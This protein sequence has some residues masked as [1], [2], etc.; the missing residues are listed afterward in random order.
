MELLAELI[1]LLLIACGVGVAVKYVRIPYT[2]ALV[3]VGLLV[4]LTGIFPEILLTEDIVF[5]LILPPLLFEGALAM[6][7]RHLR[8]NIKPIMTLATAGLLL[9]ILVTGYIT[10]MMGIP[11]LLALIFAAMVSPTDPVSVLATFRK[12]G[13]PKRLTTLLEGESII[14]DGTAVVIFSILLQMLRSD[15]SLLKGF[16]EFLLVFAGGA[17]VGF[18]LGYAAYRILTYIDDPLIE[19]TITLILAFGTFLVA[20][21]LG[22]SGVIAV[23]AAGLIIGNYGTEFSMSPSTRLTLI[24]FWSAVVFLVNSLVFILIGI[25]THIF[26]LVKY[27]NYVAIAIP[28]VLIGRAVA[29][30]PVLTAFRVKPSWQH[31][32]FWGGLHGTIPVALA[33][34]LKTPMRDVLSAMVFGVVIFSLVIQGLSLDYFARKLFRK[35]ERREKY[36][37]I[38]ARLYGIGRSAEEVKE[39]AKRGELD[40]SVAESIAKEL[41][42]R[43]EEL[44]VEIEPI[45]RDEDLRLEEYRKAWNNVLEA[46][47][48]AI[49]E[50]LRRGI[51]SE[52][53]AERLVREID[54]QKV[55]EID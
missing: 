36:E 52:E 7:I 1:T 54:Q 41:E 22:V 18:V 19:V 11:L 8:D 6:D 13:A 26:E 33:L 23:V 55:Q 30:Y 35:D 48:S 17:A 3:L 44:R 16:A 9:T 51:I 27:W 20:E 32:A 31:V 14:N 4:G 49:F 29:V 12:L 5:T 40:E 45:L 2:I 50:L 46:Q 24:N 15:V 28:A 39:L 43:A 21:Q 10:S 42:N 53:V 25:D 47:K 34:S 38:R 37:E